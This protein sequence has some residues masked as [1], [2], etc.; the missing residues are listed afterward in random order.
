MKSLYIAW[1]DFKIRVKDRK[2]FVMM[3]LTPLLLTAILGFALNSVMGGDGG[4]S[5]TTVGVYIEESDELADGFVKEVLPS[6]SFMVVK[7][8]DSE[9]EIRE[10]LKDKKID[11]G[12]LF[13]KEWSKELQEGKLKDVMVLGKPD[14]QVKTAVVETVLK[15]YGEQVQMYALTTATVM[16]DLT[17]SVAASNGEIDFGQVALEVQN[18]LQS[19]DVG[20]VAEKSVGQ[21]YVSSMQYY[22]AAM[23]VMF[24]L[25]N[26]TLGAK[27]IIQERTT[28]TLARL[29]VTPTSSMSILCGKFLGTLMFAFIQ[30]LVFL[31]ATSLFFQVD[32]GSN[33]FQVIAIGFCYS[34][35]VSGLSMTVAAFVSDEKT[36]D[37]I[38]GIGIQLLAVLGGSMLP[39]YLFPKT[40]QTVASITPNKWALTSFLDIMS[41]VSWNELYLPM[42]VLMMV[43]ILSLAIGTWKLKAN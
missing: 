9:E 36:T 19:V 12:I 13:P 10:L 2:G 33:L 20:T 41:G 29:S 18:G 27:S 30:F 43:G 25:Y 35:A 38:S 3:L 14:Q 8:G 34:V 16:T 21:K 4:F 15:S 5:E 1:K 32:W 6:M 37:A 28:E 31:T 24:L 40:V 17:S 22:A 39:I 26:M 42:T 11:V 7:R 23:A